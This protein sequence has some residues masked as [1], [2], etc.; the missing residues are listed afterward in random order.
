MV[1]TW[2]IN[3][4]KHYY[5]TKNRQVGCETDKIFPF[6]GQSVPCSLSVGAHFCQGSRH[7]L[8]VVGKFPQVVTIPGQRPFGNFP[9]LLQNL[10]QSSRSVLQINIILYA[11][12]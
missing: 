1:L 5:Y 3:T 8:R 10:T 7:V 9:G 2:K 11:F 6:G 4:T 12:S